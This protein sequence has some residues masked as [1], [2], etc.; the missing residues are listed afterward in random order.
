MNILHM[1]RKIFIFD[2]VE[3]AKAFRATT[4]GRRVHLQK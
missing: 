2:V 1:Y 3:E 4:G